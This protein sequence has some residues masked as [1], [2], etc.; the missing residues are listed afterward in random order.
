MSREPM[1]T[2]AAVLSSA[3]SGGAV[4]GLLLASGFGRRFDAGGRRNKLLARLPDGQTLVTASARALCSAL[5]HV[6][7][8]VPSRSTLLEAAL[9][10]LPVRLV[11]NSRAKEGMGAS[12]AVGI[13]ALR[14]EFPH[15]RGWLIA[16]G[17]MPFIAPRT[18]RLIADSIGNRGHRIVAACH[19]G[20]RG[21]PVGFDCSLTDELLALGGDQGASALLSAHGLA[22]VDTDDPGVIRDVDTKDDLARI[23]ESASESS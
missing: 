8:V 9:S 14:Q 12:I 20:S 3:L 19:R 21:H 4:V 11:R 7:V 13:A 17:D 6:A 22:L 2:E 15:A 23:A 18:I 16:L 1:T 5:E 10:D